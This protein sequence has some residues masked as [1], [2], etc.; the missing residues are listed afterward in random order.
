[1]EIGYRLSK[2]ETVFFVRDNGNGIDD[3]EAEKIFDLFYRG[4]TDIEGSGAG[5]AIVK[6]VIE[7][8]G[9]KIWVQAQQEEGTTMC[10]TLPK[11]SGANEEDNNGKD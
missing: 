9:G 8:H 4:T 5:L 3:N 10:F 1:M 6:K 7:G 2:N 11:Q